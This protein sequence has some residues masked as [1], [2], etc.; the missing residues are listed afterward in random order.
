[1]SEAEASR[2]NVLFGVAAAGVAAPVLAAC[3]SDGGDDTTAVEQGSGTT[4]PGAD[5]TDTPAGGGIS[6]ADIPVGGGEILKDQNVVVTQPQA[7]EFKAFSATCTHLACIV[8]Y[9][10][11]EQRI[12]CNCHD[13]EYDLTGRNVAGPPPRPLERFT[14]NRVARGQGQSDGLVVSRG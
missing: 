2:R 5:A 8:E 4:S 11:A 9:Q 3:G 14:V 10:H 13:G 6:T 12:W 7:G 1:M